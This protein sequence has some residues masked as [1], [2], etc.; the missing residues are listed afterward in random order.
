MLYTS[1]G[2]F[3]CFSSFYQSDQPFGF[4][5]RTHGTLH[6]RDPK[7]A[8]IVSYTFAEKAIMYRG[9]RVAVNCGCG[10]RQ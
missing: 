4:E 9:V 1:G 6:H 8:R 10:A 3:A 2:K 5:V 7:A